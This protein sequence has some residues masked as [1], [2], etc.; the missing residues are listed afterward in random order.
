MER[1]NVAT[2]LTWPKKLHVDEGGE[3]TH[4]A[5]EHGT[6]IIRGEPGRHRSQ[7]LVESFDRRL[8]ERIM[9]AQA[10]EKHQRA[11]RDPSQPIID[12]INAGTGTA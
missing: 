11:G 3:F 7:A 10:F 4:A 6:K 5:E 1:N 2:P 9:K 12:H 8:G